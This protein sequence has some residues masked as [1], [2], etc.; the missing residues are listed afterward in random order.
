MMAF[1]QLCSVCLLSKPVFSKK[2]S[3]VGVGLVMSSVPKR[4][5]AMSSL[6]AL[7]LSA[8]VSFLSVGRSSGTGVGR[9]SGTGVGRSSGTGV[10]R[11]DV[12]ARLRGHPEFKDP[13]CPSF[14]HLPISK[15]EE[16]LKGGS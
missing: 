4:V 13:T 11:L 3:R 8:T 5:L 6:W 9:L 16:P 15:L 10:G 12:S 7:A 14:C 1:M 2:W